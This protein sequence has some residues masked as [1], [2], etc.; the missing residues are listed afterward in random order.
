MEKA[1]N[2]QHGLQKEKKNGGERESLQNS[3]PYLDK[4]MLISKP[5]INRKGNKRFQQPIPKPYLC[6]EKGTM[7]DQS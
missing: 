1:L 2:L 5:H 6:R 7:R 4:T 3:N